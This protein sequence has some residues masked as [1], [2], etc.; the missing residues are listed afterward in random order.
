[1]G[2][3]TWLLDAWG[4][5]ARRGRYPLARKSSGMKETGKKLSNVA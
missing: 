5:V 1:M 3:L 4:I 2:P